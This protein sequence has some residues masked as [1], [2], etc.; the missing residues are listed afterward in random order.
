MTGRPETQVEPREILCPPLLKWPGGKR[1]LVNLILPLVPEQFNRYFEP[2]FGGGALFFA[3][4]PKKAYLSDKN[5]E[6]MHAYSQVRDQ[7]S[8]VIR[9]YVS[10]ATAREAII[11]SAPVA[12]SVT[13]P[14]QPALSISR[15]LRSMEYIG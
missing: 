12:R 13:P 15:P 8:A 1:S 4:Q 11:G 10:Y 9:S 2:F 14:V 3:L 6:L 7:P 5:R